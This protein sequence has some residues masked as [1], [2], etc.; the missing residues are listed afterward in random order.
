M[1]KLYTDLPKNRGER[2]FANQL[3]NISD[4]RLHIWFSIDYV[5][6]V[7]DID[8]LLIHEEIGAFVIEVKAVPIGMIEDIGYKHCKITGRNKDKG[9]TFQAYNAY[10]SLRDFLSPRLSERAPFFTATAAWSLISRKRWRENWDNKSISESWSNSLIFEEDFSG[11]YDALLDRLRYVCEN[12]PIR[13]GARVSRVRKE[14]IADL[15]RVLSPAAKPKP[16]MTDFIRLENIEKGIKGQLRRDYL[17]DHP[18]RVVFFGH[19]GTGKTFRLLQV[20]LMHAYEGKKVVFLCFNKTLAADVR[21]LLSFHEKMKMTAYH[22]EVY[23][24]FQFAASFAKR[25]GFELDKS[26]THDEWG[27]II[28]EE[29]RSTTSQDDIESFDT[30]LVDESQD[31]NSWQ[32]DLAE[33]L[34]TDGGS[35]FL[36]SGSGQELY[37][38][39]NSSKKWLDSFYDKGGIKRSLRRNFRNSLP[40]YLIAKGFYE[41]YPDVGKLN[42]VIRIDK[43]LDFDRKEGQLTSRIFFDESELPDYDDPAFPFLQEEA[44]SGECARVIEKVYA[45][46]EENEEPIDLLLLVPSSK[47]AYRDWVFSALDKL[48]AKSGIKYSNLVDEK[49]RRDVTEN[50]KIRVATYFGSRGLEGSRVIVFGFEAIEFVVKDTGATANNLAYVVLSRALFQTTIAMRS[51]NNETKSYLERVLARVESFVKEREKTSSNELF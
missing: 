18:Q 44:M 51:I 2:D 43:D 38:S 37:L 29:I 34:L 35:I 25:F 24:V 12:P 23:D 28:L 20:G 30:V 39:D 31:M 1:A 13:G 8:V 48:N 17:V 45:S 14:V 22:F 6:G 32:L 49:N 9:P 47:S 3:K 36:A 33:A 5:P 10:S 50:S 19:P 21:R 11:S 16:T 7:R 26:L 41:A 46:M 27:E 4:D 15:E 42:K 40:G